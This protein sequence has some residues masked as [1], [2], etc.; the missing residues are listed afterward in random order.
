MLE[1]GQ[2]GY[3]GAIWDTKVNGFGYEAAN[4]LKLGLLILESIGII[5][6]LYLFWSKHF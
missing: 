2:S 1:D 5:H 6:W 4:S 3:G